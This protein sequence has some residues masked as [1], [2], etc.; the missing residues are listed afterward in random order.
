MVLAN[1]RDLLSLL[2][3]SV[4]MTYVRYIIQNLDK[5]YTLP[6]SPIQQAQ[7]NGGFLSNIAG[8]LVDAA[9]DRVTGND[10]LGD[11]AG[12]TVRTFL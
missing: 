7:F 9:V 1:F 12:A 11:F 3:C 2:K 4:S 6:P 10:R 5:V 8:N